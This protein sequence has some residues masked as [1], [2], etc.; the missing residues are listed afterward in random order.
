MI[1]DG[2]DKLFKLMKVYLKVRFFWI[3]FI[4]HTNVNKDESYH[5]HLRKSNKHRIFKMNIHLCIK[6]NEIN[7]YLLTHKVNMTKGCMSYIIIVQ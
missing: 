5:L 1:F 3:L 4:V 7:E 6:F 2:Y